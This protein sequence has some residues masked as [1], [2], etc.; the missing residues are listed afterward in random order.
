MEAIVT[1]PNGLHIT[2][3]ESMEEDY[4]TAY[5]RDELLLHV[6]PNCLIA[7]GGLRYRDPPEAVSHAFAIV[8]EVMR[9]RR[10]GSMPQPDMHAA[11]D[12]ETDLIDLSA[13]PALDGMG[14]PLVLRTE[15]ARRIPIAKHHEIDPRD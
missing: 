9:R 14:D 11:C 8:D 12:S 6:L 13:A 5:F 3:D 15:Q 7:D 1:H 4:G 10:D 2:G